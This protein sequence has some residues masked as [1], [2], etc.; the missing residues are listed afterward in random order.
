MHGGGLMAREGVCRALLSDAVQTGGPGC[1]WTKHEAFRTG[2]LPTRPTVIG[3]EVSL[4]K[5]WRLLTSP[6]RGF[7]Q[8]P[9]ALKPQQ[10]AAC[11]ESRALQNPGKRYPQRAALSRPVHSSFPAP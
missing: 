5:C 8:I 7:Q 6:W 3:Q 11:K 2:Q 1:C 9:G 4:G 10:A